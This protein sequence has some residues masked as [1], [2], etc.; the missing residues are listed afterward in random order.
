MRELAHAP[1]RLD[2]PR[3]GSFLEFGKSKLPL[4]IDDF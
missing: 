1:T 2:P 4:Q 3:G